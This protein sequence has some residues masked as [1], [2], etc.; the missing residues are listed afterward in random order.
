MTDKL[1]ADWFGEDLEPED[2]EGSNIDLGDL[3]R[4]STGGGGGGNQG[5][6]SGG[7]GSDD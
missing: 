3:G 4:L 1:H 6:E 7:G 2:P 5:N